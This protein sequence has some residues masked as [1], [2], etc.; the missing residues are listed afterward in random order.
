[1]KAILYLEDGRSFMGRSFGAS[2]TTVAEVVFNTGMTG[3]QEILT[4]PSYKGQMV[5]MTAPHIGNTG[6]NDED[7]ESDVQAAGGL[8]VREYCEMPSNWRSICSLDEAMKVRGII[9]IHGIDTRALTRHIREHGAMMGIISTEIFDAAAL[10]NMLLDHPNVSA[11]D[12][13]GQVSCR[14]RQVWDTPADS[15]WYHDIAAAGECFHVVA[16]DFGI[17]HNILR[18]MTSLGFRVTLVP[19]DT[20]AEVVQELNPDGVFLSNGPGDPRALPY[21]AETVRRLAEHY[22]IF[23]ICLGHQILSLAFGAGTYKL[24][25]GHHGSNHPVRFIE[26]GR[27]EITA[28]NHNYAVDRAAVDKAGFEVTHINLNDNTVEGMRHR[29]LPVFSAQYHP[30]AAPGPHDSVYLFRQFHEMIKNR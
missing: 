17:K 13:V 7:A 4:D 23:G 5:I 28:Q 2:G 1:M 6:I 3:Y 24:K 14:E 22:P 29:D 19:S 20:L 8:I 30:E 10:K 12:L 18:L 15:R 9:G 11:I 21:A 25:F 26:T 16:F 27:V